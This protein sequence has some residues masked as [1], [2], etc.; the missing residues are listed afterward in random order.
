MGS[1]VEK[2]APGSDDG[3]K[4]GS[5]VEKSAPGS[6]A[7][8][9]NE[10]NSI[11]AAKFPSPS[12]LWG[13][14]GVGGMPRQDSPGGLGS[15]GPIRFVVP[16]TPTLPHKGGGSHKPPS[17]PPPPRWLPAACNR[18]TRGDL[19]RDGS[20]I[21]ARNAGRRRRHRSGCPGRLGLSLFGFRISDFELSPDSGP[22]P[23]RVGF[24]R[25]SNRRK[26]ASHPR[27]L[28]KI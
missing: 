3:P 10:L 1:F 5:F 9:S 16:P 21:I 22:R 13:R 4:M 28:P 6:D 23:G 24:C 14:A 11:R 25:I 26:A 19:V 2:P 8:P 7:I 17:S 15:R 20:F 27:S 12:P 18:I